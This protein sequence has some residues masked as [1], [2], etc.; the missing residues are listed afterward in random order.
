MAQDRPDLG[1]VTRDLAKGM[2]MPTTR[3]VA[4][5]KRAARY[6][7]GHPRLVQHF[8]NQEMATSLQ[9]WCD[10]DHAGCL[11]SRKSTTGGAV[12]AGGHCL[13][14]W[15]R[16]Q[17]VIALSSGEAEYY[18]LVTLMSE[19]LGIRALGQDWN[20]KYGLGVNIDATAAIGMAS[21][22]GLGKVKHID[23]VFLWVQ[24]R[25]EALKVRVAKRHT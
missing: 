10:A 3:H 18:S 16:G 20:L 6:L 24:E 9:G 19:L 21:R 11:R 12:L 7:R 15:C 23:T 2:K 13:T 5:L 8:R 4:M 14:H 25:I 1:V 22:R 17:A